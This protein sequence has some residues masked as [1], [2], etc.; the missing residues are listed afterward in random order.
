M[1]SI[2]DVSTFWTLVWA[3]IVGNLAIVI[4][5]VSVVII[6]VP[7]FYFF[8]KAIRHACH[9]GGIVS[10]I[11]IYLRRQAPSLPTIRVSRD[12]MELLEE[13]LALPPP[14]VLQLSFRGLSPKLRSAEERMFR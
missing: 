2:S 8:A 12:A 10:R 5:S 3:W 1:F 4:S 7:V 6:S 14:S 13:G 11:I 9:T